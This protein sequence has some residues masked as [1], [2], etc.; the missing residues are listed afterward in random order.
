MEVSQ[1]SG[2]ADPRHVP[3]QQH[4]AQ[5][6]YWPGLLYHTVPLKLCSDVRIARQHSSLAR[7]RHFQ[8]CRPLQRRCRRRK[9][10]H[11]MLERLELGPDAQGQLVLYWQYDRGHLS[12]QLYC[13]GVQRESPSVPC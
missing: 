1:D 6:P 4:P 12:L 5:S 7:Q 13:P 3:M 9:R 8:L 2:F 10:I 11:G